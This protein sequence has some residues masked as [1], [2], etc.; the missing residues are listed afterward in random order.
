MLFNVIIADKT[1]IN[2]QINKMRDQ[3]ILLFT[4]KNCDGC[5]VAKTLITNKLSVT[6]KEIKL[7]KYDISDIKNDSF[8]KFIHDKINIKDFPTTV[9]VDDHVILQVLRG[10]FSRKILNKIVDEYFV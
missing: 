2:L 1:L 7:V 9:F 6:N 10:T 8:A 5:Y 4:I 3:R